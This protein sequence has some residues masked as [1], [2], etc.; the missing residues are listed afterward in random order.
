[1]DID[2]P[3]QASQLHITPIRSTP[4][5]RPRR[6]ISALSEL[7]KA[8]PYAYTPHKRSYQLRPETPPTPTPKSKKPSNP[9][10]SSFISKIEMVKTDDASGETLFPITHA[11]IPVENT[12][13]SHTA[14]IQAESVPMEDARAAFRKDPMSFNLKDTKTGN[15]RNPTT[16]ELSALFHRFPECQECRITNGMLLLR[17]KTPPHDLS[18][19]VAGLPTM[20]LPLN[21]EFELIPGIPGHPRVQDM[22]P[23]SYMPQRESQF[24]FLDRV[25]VCLLEHKLKPV[26][27]SIYL[28][29]LV[30]ELADSIPTSSLPGRLGGFTPYYCAGKPAFKDKTLSHSRLITP[31]AD[32]VDDS[33]YASLGLS[34]GVRVC[35]VQDAA[36]SGL[37]LANRITGERRLT[38]ANHAFLDTNEVYH[39]HTLPEYHIGRITHRYPKL[40]IAL[41]KLNDGVG[42]YNSYYFD[43]PVPKR[44]SATV[45]QTGQASSVN[46]QPW[47]FIESPFTGLVPLLYAGW[48]AGFSDETPPQPYHQMKCDHS[49]IL[50]SMGINLTSLAKG[51]C[52][53]PIVLDDFEV[54]ESDKGSVLGFFAWTDGR[55]IENV[56]VPVLD[57]IIAEGWEVA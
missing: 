11:D 51:I 55:V 38:V 12:S 53:S 21:E 27:A 52:G 18:L 13:E 24:D 31:S 26:S 57:Q 25:L 8:A 41:V 34:P 54:S 46:L 30:I 42:Y 5:R 39:P 32:V 33:D 15:V 23:S 44:L 22:L 29:T 20:F 17:C 36:T 19:I 40:D 37:V 49:Y 4:R 7:S 10:M 50:R 45:A 28:G 6:V 16:E 9:Q 14:R 2:T 48:M 43:A 3:S 35:G 1:M 56:F 47:Y